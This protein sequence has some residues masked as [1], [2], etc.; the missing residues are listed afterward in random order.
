MNCHE[1]PA[2]DDVFEVC[3]K[4]HTEADSLV[5]LLRMIIWMIA[6]MREDQLENGNGGLK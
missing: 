5:C 4:K 2:W 6:K 1:C 3:A